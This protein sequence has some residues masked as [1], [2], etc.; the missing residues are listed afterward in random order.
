VEKSATSDPTLENIVGAKSK[1]SHKMEKNFKSN[2]K[3][4]S[5]N[6]T[7]ASTDLSS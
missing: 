7:T 4:E 5:Q 3:S 1:K 2:K 6:I